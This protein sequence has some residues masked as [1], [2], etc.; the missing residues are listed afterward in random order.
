M[1]TFKNAEY[2]ITVKV[3]PVSRGYAVVI[4]DDDSGESLEP[5]IFASEAAAVDLAKKAAA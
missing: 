3:V 5:Q 2:G 4:T 1:T